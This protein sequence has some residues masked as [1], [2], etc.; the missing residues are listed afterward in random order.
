V[1]TVGEA[2]PQVGQNAE[3]V[4]ISARHVGQVI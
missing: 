1:I 3:P 2:L 4:G